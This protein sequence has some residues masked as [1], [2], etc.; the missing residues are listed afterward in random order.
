MIRDAS[1]SVMNRPFEQPKLED[2]QSAYGTFYVPADK[3]YP[4]IEAIPLNDM[5]RP[6]ACDEILGI[7]ARNKLLMSGGLPSEL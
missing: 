7:V 4:Y 1:Q 5:S 2:G 6:N 3:L